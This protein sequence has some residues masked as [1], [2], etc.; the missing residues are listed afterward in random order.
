LTTAAGWRAGGFDRARRYVWSP[1]G[2]SL[3][4]A[5]GR[6]ISVAG[7]TGGVRRVVVRRG[8][9]EVAWS[10]AGDRLAFTAVVGRIGRGE[11]TELFV[12]GANGGAPVRLT[13]D[14]ADVTGPAWAPG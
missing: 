2:G 8:V 5:D 9:R 7:R 10:P 11:R 1:D 3:A 12:V 6:G 14:L 13:R 4:L